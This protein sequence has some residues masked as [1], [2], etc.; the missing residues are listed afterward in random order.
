[1]TDAAKV[2]VGMLLKITYKH[3]LDFALILQ[4]FLS[5]T[6]NGR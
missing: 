2:E 3:F 6:G 4:T 5:K 1:M